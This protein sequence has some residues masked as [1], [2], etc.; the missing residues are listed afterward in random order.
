MKFR[1]LNGYILLIILSIIT[2]GSFGQSDDCATAEPFCTGITY[3]FPLATGTSAETGPYYDC[4]LTQPNPVWYY[5]LIDDP[6]TLDIHMNS[7]PGV[8][9]I[10][11]CAWG[12]FASLS[13]V[14]S[15]LTSSNVVDCSYSTADVEDCNITGAVTGM[16]YMLCITNFSNSTTNV[17]FS[18][19]G[20][21]GSTDCGVMSP[22]NISSHTINVGACISGTDMFTVTGT[23]TYNDPP[24]TGTLLVQDN[25]GVSQ[26]F[27]PP[28]T[29]PDAFTLSN[30]PADGLPH[31]ISVTFSAD[32]F[33]TYEITYTAPGP[34]SACSVNAGVDAEVCGLTYSP[35]NG[36]YVATDYNTL[37]TCPSAGVV[38]TVPT[39]YNSS[40]TVPTAGTYIF[41]WTITN[42][43]GLTCSD[44]VSIKFNNIPTSTFTTTNIPC[45]GNN[46][47]ITYT[48]NGLA[49]ST[50]NWNFGGG[51]VASGSGQ[52]PYQVNWATAGTQ[53]IT[54]SVTENSCTGS[55]TTHTV[56]NP[57]DLISSISTDPVDCASG[58]NGT[59][60]LTVS[61][62][63]PVYNYTWSEGT[64]PPYPA[65]SYSVTITDANGCTN[66]EP[67]SIIEPNSITI[68][69]SHTDLL[70]YNDNSGTASVTV[71]GG[72]APYVYAWPGGSTTNSATGLPAGPVIVTITDANSC[73]VTNTITINQPTQV[74]ATISSSSDATCAGYCDGQATVTVSG[75]TPAYNYIWSNLSTASTATLLCAGNYTVTVF[76]SNNCTA[77][78]SETISAPAGMVANISSTQ[79][80]SCNGECDGT[81]TVNVT[82][83]SSPYT[84]SWPAAG[85]SNATGVNLCVGSHTVTVTDSHLCTTTATAVISEPSILTATISAFTDATCYGYCDGTA[86]VVPA[87]G[88]P[89]Y[90]YFWW[91][92]T[93][94][95]SAYV[96]ILC[97]GAHTVTITDNNGCTATATVAI[98]QP[99]GMTT[100]ISSTNLSCYGICDGTAS[101]V[102]SDGTPPYTYV[103]TSGGSTAS[104]NS[105]CAGNH[106]VNITDGNG[107]STTVGTTLTE[108]GPISIVASPDVWVCNGSP[109][110]VSGTATG[111]S[112]PYIYY[113][114][115]GGMTS[116]QSITTSQ[117]TTIS[118][119]VADANGCFSNTDFV[120]IYVYPALWVNAE[121]E[122]YTICPG[123][124]STITVS[125]G[126]G[127][128]GPYAISLDDEPFMV[129]P[130]NVH[131]TETTLYVISV[132]DMCGTATAHDT[133]QVI[134]ADPPP[135]EF[136]AN[137]YE[138]CQPFP[139]TFQPLV[140]D[141][142]FEY[143]WDFGDGYINNFSDDF[144]PTHNY[145]ND[146]TF[147][148]TL[149]VTSEEGC[150]TVNEQIDMITIWEKPTARFN[151]EP[152]TQTI[153]NPYVYFLN[154]SSNTYMSNWDF[155]DGDSSNFTNP[156]HHYEDTGYYLVELIVI[157]EHGCR[158]T[159]SSPVWIEEEF[160]FYA[161]DGFTPNNDNIND[162]FFVVGEG[163]D[164]ENFLI[165]I[166][167]RWGEVIFETRDYETES[168]WVSGWDG[169]AK[170]GSE[171]CPSAVYTW[172]VTYRDRRGVEHQEAG[173]VT[174]MR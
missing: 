99:D 143:F 156:L 126:G 63:T 106:V 47:T 92:G 118:V 72:T 122:T 23:I 46:T 64:P 4:L 96:S 51:T 85:G 74:T 9:D 91:A 169:R 116:T 172:L 142:A 95:A 100:L 115:N 164:P 94:G 167:D 174:L 18:Q 107:C 56:N 38:F 120:S 16:Y 48:G 78:A 66:V 155:G 132:D 24:T 58:S 33:C 57:P 71:G 82:S 34:C 29:S 140:E 75:G 26:S 119:Y 97:A 17:A 161:P 163:I 168:P 160:A 62:G 98:N 19:T 8:Y 117:D 81:A 83:G 88:T 12:P 49:G 138:G 150:V 36:S 111:G 3:N 31:T 151:A 131:P 152:M 53:T 128:G 11:F 112:S 45:F 105:L 79:S 159:I 108:P 5:L 121:P 124:T 59:V 103:W 135:A 141:D 60:N 149:T 133:V 153:I 25:S 129:P 86:T 170:G 65:G 125:Y 137:Y 146:G 84:Y 54:L 50:Y 67:F 89:P 102:V 154:L 113:W 77:T 139:I 80:V 6:G 157:T 28:F 73:T 30:I 148:V 27:S 68:T 22:C 2:L 158:D 39:A 76:D 14:C 40:V 55:T 87:G 43:S 70:C 93:S 1:K 147:N 134:V 7:T 69:P 162:L 37:W 166:Y 15:N 35:L 110:I 101:V 13:G 171:L 44:Q 130:F 127:D 114:S 145:E 52:G 61:G 136:T 20:G 173:A 10:D 144:S 41:T 42:S 90:S 109:T 104:V 165:I 32:P 21:T 123:D